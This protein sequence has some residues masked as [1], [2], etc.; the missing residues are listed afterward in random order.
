[1]FCLEKE[2]LSTSIS[3]TGDINTGWECWK[4]SFLSTVSE[5]IPKTKLSG[6]NPLP[7]INS[8]ILHLIKKKSLFDED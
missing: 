6:R 4:N 3:E 5:Y 1:M 2:D 7:W 8:S